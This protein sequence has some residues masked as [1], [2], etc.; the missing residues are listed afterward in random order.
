MSPIFCALS[1]LSC[2]RAAPQ[3]VW[4]GQ[5]DGIAILH[6]AGKR[7]TVQIQ[8]ARRWS[9]RSSTFPM[10]CPTPSK[11]VRVE[12]LEGRGYVH[13]VDQ[14]SIEN[15]YTLAVAIED[16]Q[17]GSSFY[18]IALYW[19]ASSNGFEPGAEK[20]DQVAWSGRVDRAAVISCHKQSCVSSSEQGAE[21]GAPVADEHFKFSRPLPDRDYRSPAG[22]PGRPRR[23]PFDRAA[24]RAQQLHRAGFHSRSAA[25]A[26]EY[27]FTLVWNRVDREAH[28][29]SPRRFPTPAGARISWSGTVDGRVRVTLQ[30]GA[31]FSEVLEGAPIA[32][33]QRKCS[34]RYRARRISRRPSGSCADAGESR[35]SSHHRRKTITG[36]FLRLTIRSPARITRSTG[37]VI[38]VFPRSPLAFGSWKKLDPSSDYYE[39]SGIPACFAIE[40]YAHPASGLAYAT[41]CS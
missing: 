20:T 38:R 8:Q 16:R 37:L 12:V 10:R 13:V 18:S 1:R 35:L 33:E 19:D 29:G 28:Q 21:Q 27:S 22:G 36:W 41:T 15:H 14:P 31:S 11:K 25:G 24:A 40:A 5:V 34:G 17:P 7:L 6:L 2:S 39:P 32:G 26:G 9:A 3:F 23:N 30:G 4:Q